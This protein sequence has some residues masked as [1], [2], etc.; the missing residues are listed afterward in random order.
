MLFRSGQI[1]RLAVIL[2][3]REREG[4]GSRYDRL[5]AEREIAELRTD[6]IAASVGIAAARSRIGRFL[7]EDTRILTVRGTL[8]VPAAPPEMAVLRT[9]A[10]ETRAD[11]R[12]EQKTVDRFRLE[13][14]AARRLRIPEPVVSGGVKR[15]DTASNVTR[16]G[17]VFG[18]SI[19]LL[20]FN[21][22]RYE[23]ARYQAEQAQAQARAA[24]I[25]RQIQSEVQGAYDVLA[26]RRQALAAYQ[27]TLGAEGAELTRITRIAYDEGEVGILELLDSLRVTRLANLR[28]LELQ[29]G[30]REAQIELERVLGFELS[31][32]EVRP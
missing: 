3:Q 21:D 10:L 13:E 25:A 22:G 23:V 31:G 15:A 7:P 30:I 4:E 17:V 1:E 32:G 8:A 9:R 18:V 24:V 28:V 11:Y 29:A 5:R 12:A 26:T 20:V 6:V 16:T 19:P 14:A 2:R 27:A